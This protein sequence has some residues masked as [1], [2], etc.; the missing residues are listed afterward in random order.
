MRFYSRSNRK[1]AV[2]NRPLLVSKVYA[3]R[4]YLVLSETARE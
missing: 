3:Y 1:G 2:E 4:V